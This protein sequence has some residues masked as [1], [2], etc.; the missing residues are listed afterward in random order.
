MAHAARA[1]AKTALAGRAL[2]LAAPLPGDTPVV[3]SQSGKG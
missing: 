1:A 3:G 2:A